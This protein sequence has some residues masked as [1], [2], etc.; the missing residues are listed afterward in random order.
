VQLRV[1]YRSFAYSADDQAEK[2]R[3]LIEARAVPL[4]PGVPDELLIEAPLVSPGK[5]SEVG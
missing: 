1:D 4:L 3:L 2:I 5:V